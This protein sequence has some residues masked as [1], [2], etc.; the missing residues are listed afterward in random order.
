MRSVFNRNVVIR[1]ISVRLAVLFVLTHTTGNEPHSLCRPAQ[2]KVWC[3]R[4]MCQNFLAAYLAEL[5]NIVN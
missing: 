1:R 5:R 4:V 2:R 3:R